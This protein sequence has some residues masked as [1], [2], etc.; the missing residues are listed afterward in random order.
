MMDHSEEKRFA[1]KY[2]RKSRRERVV[3]ELTSSKRRYEG[4]SR[5]CHLA[6][7]LL[8]PKRMLMTGEDLD[9]REDFLRFVK[10]HD[11]RCFIMSPDPWLDGEYMDTAA[12]VAQ[13]IHSMDAVIIMG[14]DFAVVF[15]EVMKGGRGK[16]LL[17]ENNKKK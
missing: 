3:F 8:D 6:G 15:G 14:S 13:G 1:E 9:R 16:Y 10:E 11:E 17:T 5:F 7:E 4:L 2:I 12:A